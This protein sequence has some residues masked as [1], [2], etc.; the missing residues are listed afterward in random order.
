MAPFLRT[1]HRDNTDNINPGVVL[2]AFF[3][4][5][6]TQIMRTRGKIMI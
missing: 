5:S 6:H 4:G 3:I 2:T 1:P